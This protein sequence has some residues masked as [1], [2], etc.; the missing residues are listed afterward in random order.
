ASV[1]DGALACIENMFKYAEMKSSD[2]PTGD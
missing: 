2:A 1:R